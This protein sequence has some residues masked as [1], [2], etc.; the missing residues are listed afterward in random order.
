MR[1]TGYGHEALD[2]CTYLDTVDRLQ[3][4]RARRGPRG[5]ARREAVVLRTWRCRSRARKAR[6]HVRRAL[7]GGRR[8]VHA[9]DESRDRDARH[10]D[11]GRRTDQ[12]SRD[13]G[14][15]GHGF[16]LTHQELRPGLVPEQSGGAVQDDGPSGGE[17]TR[18]ER[19]GDQPDGARRERRGNPRGA[20][21]LQRGNGPARQNHS[22]AGWPFFVP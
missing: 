8:R 13:H 22:T 5:C 7:H 20:Y 14:A 16:S 21:R 19:D 10:D 9:T 6:P 18:H 3:R 12:L 11:L 15:A 4:L 2:P 17:K 1:N